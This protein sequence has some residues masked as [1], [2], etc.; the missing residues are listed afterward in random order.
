MSQKIDFSLAPVNKIEEALCERITEIRLSRNINQTNL[1]KEAGISRRTI[2]RMEN[3]EGVSLETFI[4]VL[5]ALNLTHHLE[6]LLP[7]PKIRPIERVSLQGQQRRRASSPR[8][9]RSK[10]SSVPGDLESH[11]ASKEEDM[12]KTISDS[13][14]QNSKTRWEWDDKKG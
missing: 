14:T 1:A 3:G 6:A 13:K 8:R 4:R 10:S 2:S 11:S 7:D 5:R 9:V 12:N